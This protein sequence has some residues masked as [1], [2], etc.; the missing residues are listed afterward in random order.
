MHST[1]HHW[2]HSSWTFEACIHGILYKFLVPNT[3]SPVLVSRFST[4]GV[5]PTIE[6]ELLTTSCPFR[7]KQQQLHFYLLG[8]QPVFHFHE[9]NYIVLVE[10]SARFWVWRMLHI[11]DITISP[12]NGGNQIS[13][14]F[15]HNSWT[16]KS[17]TR[18][19]NI[20]ENIIVLFQSKQKHKTW[21]HLLVEF[22]LLQWLT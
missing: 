1:P 7:L 10:F 15:Q 19:K 13:K 20:P 14:E 17:F 9:W 16:K 12:C 3:S 6:V 21:L 11:S 4:F 8:P 18:S 22:W 5:F 2:H